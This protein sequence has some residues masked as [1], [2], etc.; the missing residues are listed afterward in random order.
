M[1]L[2]EELAEHGQPRTA[3][4]KKWCVCVRG[5]NKRRTVNWAKG[6]GWVS[7]V[8][9]GGRQVPVDQGMVQMGGAERTLEWGRH[10]ACEARWCT[11]STA[12][13]YLGKGSS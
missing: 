7:H 4:L 9:R 5:G 6:Q 3:S 10:R 1:F 13:E 12:A 2:G 8:A 11:A